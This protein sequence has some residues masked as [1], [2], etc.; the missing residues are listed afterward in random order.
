MIKHAQYNVVTYHWVLTAENAENAEF[1]ISA[2]SAT[3]AVS[4]VKFPALAQVI[5]TM[6]Y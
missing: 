4:A 2:T 3:S 1:S 5:L 6:Q